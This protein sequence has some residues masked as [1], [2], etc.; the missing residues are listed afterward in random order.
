MIEQVH[1]MVITAAQTGVPLQ[2]TMSFD[3]EDGDVVAER[4]RINNTDRELLLK[5]DSIVLQ[6]YEKYFLLLSSLNSL[7]SL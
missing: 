7:H 3:N 5:T 6:K 4:N 1:P 2:R